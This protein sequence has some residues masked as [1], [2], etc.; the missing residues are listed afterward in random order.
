MRFRIPATRRG[1]R[2]SVAALAALTAVVGVTA[3]TQPH[4]SSPVRPAPVVNPYSPAYHHP[5]RHGAVPTLARQ[6]LMNAWRLAH[7]HAKASANNLVYG[8]GIDGIGVTTGKEKVYL[9]FYGSQW[10]SP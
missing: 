6:R 10:G 1:T 4:G 8:G 5:Y 7:P 2:G 3:A 9:V